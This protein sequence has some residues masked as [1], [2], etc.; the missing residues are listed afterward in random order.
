MSKNLFNSIVIIDFIPDGEINTARR[1]LED[2][3]T[4]AR[5]FAE[6]L[7]TDYFRTESLS[8]FKNVIQELILNLQT[9]RIFPLLHFEGHGLTDKSGIAFPNGNICSWIEFNQIITPLNIAMGLNLMIVM[10]T[11]YGSSLAKF[12]QVNEKAPLWGLIGPTEEIYP[13]KLQGDF[14][15]FYRTFFEKS[16]TS[17][18]INALNSTSSENFYFRTTAKEFFIHVWRRYKQDFFTDENILKRARKMYR[19]E[20]SKNTQRVQSVGYYKRLLKN[21]NIE[22]NIFDKI[23]ETYFM[24]DLY[25]S[26]KSRFSIS[27]KDVNEL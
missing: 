27:Y 1:L 9:K 17:L 24:Y 14:L 13:P 25:P 23:R 20:K 12:I 7:Q 21:T 5:P 19:D 6:E 4:N 16:S 3:D 15:S 2:L 8:E 22:K 26:N 11:C 10:A 18:A